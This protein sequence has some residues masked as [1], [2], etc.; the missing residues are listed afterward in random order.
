M[1]VHVDVPGIGGGLPAAPGLSGMN[2]T[3]ASSTSRSTPLGRIR[4]ANPAT[5]SSTN[6]AAASERAMVARAIRRARHA[7]RSPART[8]AQVR[9]S[10]CRSSRASPR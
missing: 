9:G 2:R 4:C 10:R 1:G 5:W 7:G 8:R 6:P 3:I